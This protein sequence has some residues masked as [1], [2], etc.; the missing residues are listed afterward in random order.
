MPTQ[1]KSL[2]NKWA[3]KEWAVTVKMLAEGRYILLLR[4][5]GI[6]EIKDG[7]KVGATEFFLFPTYVHQNEED[8][9]QEARAYLRDIPPTPV[10]GFVPLDYYAKLVGVA[11]VNSL[12]PLLKLEGQ[13]ILSRKAVEERFHYKKD[14]LNVLALRLYKFANRG[15]MIKNT[16]KYDGCKSWVEL[17]NE[18]PAI[19]LEPVLGDKEFEEKLASVK[20]AI[21][22][23][24]P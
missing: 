9:A 21:N 4:K 11:K 5:G 1:V 24:N 22:I 19:G 18:L 7:F 17:N 16:P 14:G 23:S 2:A 13:H 8:L 12:E 20:R 10:E 15:F 3:L 6:M